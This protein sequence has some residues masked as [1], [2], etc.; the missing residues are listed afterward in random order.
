MSAAVVAVSLIALVAL[1]QI[2][3]AIG[4]PWGI[5]AWGGQNH[6]VLSRRLWIASAV[7]AMVLALTGWV[8]P[9][10]SSVVDVSPIPSDWL[11]VA[12]WVVT[13]YF[14][15]GTL[16]NLASRSKPERLWGPISLVIAVCCGLVAAG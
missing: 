12:T 14:L 1:F 4:A 16:A 2:A 8:V 5:A 13:G 6:G 10:K 9:A 7:S 3:L 11:T 15:L